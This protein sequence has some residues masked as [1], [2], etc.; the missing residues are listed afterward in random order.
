MIIRSSN[1]KFFSPTI[2]EFKNDWSW[3]FNEAVFQTGIFLEQFGRMYLVRSLYRK[4]NLKKKFLGWKVQLL[5]GVSD[6]KDLLYPFWN[7]SI[8]EENILENLLQRIGF[9]PK[10]ISKNVN[11]PEKERKRR[12]DFQNVCKFFI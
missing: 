8:M 7:I 11:T 9:F 12:Y 1:S 10:N 6:S 2:S 5:R 3:D 4:E